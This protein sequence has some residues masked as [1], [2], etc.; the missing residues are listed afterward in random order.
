MG[1]DAV[2]G[3][4]AS[5]VEAAGGGWRL[6]WRS[7]LFAFFL[8]RALVVASAL[9]AVALAQQWEGPDREAGEIHLL[10]AESI[11]TLRDRIVANDAGWYLGIAEHG[12]EQRPFDA[13]R[14]ANWA[15]F[16]LHPLLWRGANLAGLDPAWTG[17]LLSNLLFL[18][19]LAVMH[20]W[21]QSLRDGETADR[22]LLCLALFPTAYFFSLPWSESLFLLLSATSLLAMQQRA[23]GRSSIANLLAA[24][25][26]P[27]GIFLSALLW[28][29]ARDG[30]RWP[31]ARHWLL[32][33]VGGIGLLAFM[34]LLWAKTG[35]AFAFSDIQAR[36]GRDGGSLT[37]HLVRWVTDPL[38]LAEPWNVRWINNGAL[39]LGLAASAW[40]WRRQERGLALFAFLCLL[41]PWTTGTLMSM[42]RYVVACPPLFLAFACWLRGRRMETTWLTAS[43]CLLAGMS[44]CHVLG[45]NFAG[46]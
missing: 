10:T 9:V 39:V 26:R 43:A 30:R 33:A 35:N 31:A 27:T 11:A 28:W 19:A 8:S 12:Y 29:Q 5:E 36:W 4:P 21:L 32:A 1:S 14:Q 40:L 15:F 23:W 38:L 24:A 18:A 25:T 17:L 22:A 34:L 7:A 42:G 46:A 37:K 3:A 2:A 20:R 6:A 45:A 41:L 44:A 13:S 16:P